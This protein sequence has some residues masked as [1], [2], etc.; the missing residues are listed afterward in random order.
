[1]SFYKITDPNE[2]RRMFEKLA[3]T[4]KNVREQFLEEKIGD[5]ESRETLK[6]MF[7]PVTESQR[8][9]SENI[10]EQLAPIRDKVL[11]L[12]S[13]APALP[14]PAPAPPSPAPALSEDTMMLG[15][16]A[17]DYLEKYLNKDPQVDQ[18]FGIYSD[19][20]GT[21][22]IGN[23]E[24]DVE[25]DDLIVEGEIYSGTRG[26]WELLI[27]KKPSDRIYNSDDYINYSRLLVHTNTMRQ[28]N[29]P[30]NPRPKSSDGWKWMNIVKPIWEGTEQVQGTGTRTVVIPS[31]PNALI[32]RLDLL[33]ASKE[34]GNTGTRNELVSI[35][36]EL[37]R[38]KVISKNEYKN[39][40]L[41]L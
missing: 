26:L 13:S 28:K 3:Q 40:M 5:I 31:N 1:M 24:V 29:D 17:A 9:L 19:E 20:A 23:K 32:E 8:E 16:I 15:P 18:T 12:P 7:K 38:Q 10:K 30:R 22:K 36:D 41:K 21:W 6:K 33:M 2:R 35:C 25:G 27:S 14:S 37:L 4:R 11:A 34:A 39:I